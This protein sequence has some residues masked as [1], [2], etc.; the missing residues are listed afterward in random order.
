MQKAQVF[1]HVL[2]TKRYECYYRLYEVYQ[3]E[4]ATKSMKKKAREKCGQAK[5]G[6]VLQEVSRSTGVEQQPVSDFLLGLRRRIADD[7]EDPAA[8]SRATKSYLESA[9]AQ[10]Q[11][12]VANCA[13]LG[14]GDIV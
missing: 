9:Q 6:P 2:A 4:K 13:E 8:I 3:N 10:A 12:P 11:P 14:V 7:G 5:E 1:K